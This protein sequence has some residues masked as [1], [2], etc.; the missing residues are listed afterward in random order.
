MGAHNRTKVSASLRLTTYSFGASRSNNNVDAVTAATVSLEVELCNGPLSSNLISNRSA[1]FESRA[2]RGAFWHNVARKAHVVLGRPSLSPTSPAGATTSHVDC[3]KSR[4]LAS[5]GSKEDATASRT[6]SVAL[7]DLRS[8]LPLGCT[9]SGRS[10][11]RA[12]SLSMMVFVA[13]CL[14]ATNAESNP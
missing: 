6:P 4:H 3:A 5:N 2:K 7:K 11:A 8:F 10:N 14:S 13:W 12:Q 1:S 9:L